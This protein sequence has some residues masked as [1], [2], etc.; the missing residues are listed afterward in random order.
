MKLFAILAIATAA[1]AKPAT[2][3]SRDIEVDGEVDIATL[4]CTTPSYICKPDFSGWLVCNVDGY[5]LVSK[6]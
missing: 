6:T 4:Q 3:S 5:Y 1:L 2:K